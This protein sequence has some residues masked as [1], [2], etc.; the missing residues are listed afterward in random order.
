MIDF[1]HE[2]ENGDDSYWDHWD[3]PAEPGGR[4]GPFAAPTGFDYTL[5]REIGTLRRLL[6]RLEA[7]IETEEEPERLVLPLTRL[8][9]SIARTIRIHN[10]V[11]GGPDD[12]IQESIIRVFREMGLDGDDPWPA[13]APT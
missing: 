3:I 12:P 1:V 8:V 7:G 5:T 6:D 2:L 10:G 4:S 9:E 13:T 11:S